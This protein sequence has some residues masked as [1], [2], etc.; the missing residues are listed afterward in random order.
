[1]I[2][3]VGDKIAKGTGVLAKVDNNQTL[4]LGSVGLWERPAMV[5]SIAFLR[6]MRELSEARATCSDDEV[7]VCIVDSGGESN[8]QKIVSPGETILIGRVWDLH[9]GQT[10]T[11]EDGTKLEA[12]SSDGPI[13]LTLGRYHL[14]VIPLGQLPKALP[15][16]TREA[17]ASLPQRSFLSAMGEGSGTLLLPERFSGAFGTTSVTKMPSSIGLRDVERTPVAPDDRLGSLVVQSADKRLKF[18][19]G[20][21]HLERG[22][23][24]GRYDRCIGSGLDR[25]VS[26]VHLMIAEVGG[27]IVAIDT[28]STVGC[29]VDSERIK[30]IRLTGETKVRLGKKSYIRWRPRPAKG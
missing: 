6:Y 27:A 2:K 26:R 25:A 9:T 24:V 11:G 23:L 4:H 20:K 10:L 14:A 7:F 16:A 18:Y 3:S 5:A 28:A 17:W 15:V 13:F 29:K 22:I 12:L 21:E 19:V 1:M 8:R 30:S